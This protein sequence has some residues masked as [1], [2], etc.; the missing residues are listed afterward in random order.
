MNLLLFFLLFYPLA[1][2]NGAHVHNYLENICSEFRYGICEF[3]WLVIER[4][5]H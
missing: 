2:K 3:I 4:K 5:H 1:K